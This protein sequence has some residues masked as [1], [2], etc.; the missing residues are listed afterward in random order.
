MVRAILAWKAIT[1]SHA[2]IKVNITGLTWLCDFCDY[3]EFST[4]LSPA[5]NLIIR[6]CKRQQD[7]LLIAIF[8]RLQRNLCLL[9]KILL[10]TL[11]PLK[12][13]KQVVRV[14]SQQLETRNKN[15]KNN[16]DTSIIFNQNILTRITN[17]MLMEGHK[18]Y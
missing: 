16:N 1:T 12:V 14:F 4:L 3:P 9:L 17:N 8:L 18:V 6:N 10:H 5:I 2:L 15:Q 7:L 13:N 11:V